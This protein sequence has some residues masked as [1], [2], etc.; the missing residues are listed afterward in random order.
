MAF[1]VLL[2]ILSLLKFNFTVSV[3]LTFELYDNAK[4]CFY[5]IIDK[6][7]STTLEYQVLINYFYF[8]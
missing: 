5:E 8:L 6:N 4:D 3:E 2:F 1:W 7:T